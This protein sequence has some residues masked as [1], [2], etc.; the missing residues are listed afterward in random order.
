M[1]LEQ[2]CAELAA[3][4]EADTHVMTSW[5]AGW[6]QQG[7]AQPKWTCWP[8]LSVATLG[9]DIQHR[10]TEDRRTEFIWCTAHCEKNSLLSEGCL[11]LECCLTCVKI[12]LDPSHNVPCCW[13]AEAYRQS[14]MAGHQKWLV[15]SHT[16]CQS[17]SYGS[18]LCCLMISCICLWTAR[19]I[20]F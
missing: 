3:T 1:I 2:C 6:G 10:Q 19:V 5:V 8:W 7:Y 14:R 13:V 18:A 20:S 11:M 4:L 9:V 12:V 16:A 15:A 17:V